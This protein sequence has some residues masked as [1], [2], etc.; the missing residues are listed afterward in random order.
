M[1]HEEIKKLLALYHEGE[2]NDE[3]KHLVEKHLAECPEC[4]READE[5]HQLEE[6]LGEM[7]LKEPSKELWEIYW[8]S[9][10]NRIERRTGWVV[11]SIG[12]IILLC[13]GAYQALKD[14]LNNPHIPT[15]V[16]VGLLTLVGGGM[17]LFVS[18]L[19]EQLFCRK[20]ERYKE[21]NI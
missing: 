17:I 1:K 11:L 21:I 13:F 19:K 20:R 16:V 6:V 3:E 9:V 2:L 14:I 5:F 12:L 15:I 10:Y 18:I 4:Q 7:K 8:A